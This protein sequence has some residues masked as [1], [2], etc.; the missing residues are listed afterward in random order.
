LHFDQTL[1]SPT[2]DQTIVKA[3]Q[4]IVS[5]DFLDDEHPIAWKS[6]A[7]FTKDS[8]LSTLAAFGLKAPSLCGDGHNYSTLIPKSGKYLVDKDK[9]HHFRGVPIFVKSLQQAFND[10]ES[11]KQSSSVMF[12]AASPD[13]EGYTKIPGVTKYLAFNDKHTDLFF[14]AIKGYSVKEKE[15]TL[16]RKVEQLVGKVDEN[17]ER[18]KRAKAPTGGDNLD[19]ASKYLGFL[20]LGGLQEGGDAMEE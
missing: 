15:S 17:A 16:K 5:G 11:V 4:T 6:E 19:L 10:W 2:H 7:M 9:P 20:T 13:K 8:T 12:K 1:W 3:T 18:K 14:T